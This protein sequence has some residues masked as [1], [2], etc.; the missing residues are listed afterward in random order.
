MS[1]F[2]DRRAA[3]NAEV[4]FWERPRAVGAAVA[5]S[6]GAIMQAVGLDVAH[7][8]VQTLTVMATN[9]VGWQLI[10]HAN[11]RAG[12]RDAMAR[13]GDRGSRADGALRQGRDRRA[14][15]RNERSA[16]FRAR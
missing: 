16:D 10:A 12:E 8:P 9:A 6:T 2:A 5:F 14:T 7:N 4:G 11:R 15:E 13:G 3:R 1:G